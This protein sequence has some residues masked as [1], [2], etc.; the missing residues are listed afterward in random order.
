[1]TGKI[2]FTICFVMLWIGMLTL[3]ISPFI[4]ISIN[5]TV[6]L[7]ILIFLVWNS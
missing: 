5:F 3:F 6:L 2:F 1:M 4:G 7:A